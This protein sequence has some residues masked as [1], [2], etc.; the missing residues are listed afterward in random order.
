MFRASAIVHLV[1]VAP[2]A[3][4]AGCAGPVKQSSCTRCDAGT[5]GQTDVSLLVPDDTATYEDTSLIDQTELPS[6]DDAQA[7]PDVLSGEAARPSPMPDGGYMFYEDFESGVAEGWEVEEWPDAG[8][9]DTD[10]SVI[11]IDTGSVYAEGVLDQTQ[12]HISYVSL[13]ASSD[14]IVEATMRVADFYDPTPSSAAALFARYDS[15]SDSGYFV[16]L[17]GDGSVIIRKRTNGKNA[18][19]AAGV[20][21]GIVSGDWHVVRLEV[22]GNTARAFLDGNWVYTAVD[23][24]PLSGGTVALGSYGATLEVDSVFIAL[25]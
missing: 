8:T 10:W 2:F 19:W 1:I 18:S 20:D 14:Q 11:T 25:P 16:A 24:D 6:L 17:R 5:A 22:V 15:V 4:G 23:S 12:W 9:H 21:A 3:I 13:K 7:K